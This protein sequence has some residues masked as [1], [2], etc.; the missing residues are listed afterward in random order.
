MIPSCTPSPLGL[1]SAVAPGKRQKQR[2][3][4]PVSEVFLRPKSARIPAV[5][6]SQSPA[7]LGLAGCAFVRPRATL[8]CGF[9]ARQLPAPRRFV[10]ELIGDCTHE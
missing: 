9:P 10:L 2:S 1:F 5:V 4:L 3:T 7:M 8:L 6:A